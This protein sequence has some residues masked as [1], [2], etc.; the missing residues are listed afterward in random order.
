MQTFE[1]RPLFFLVFARPAVF[2]SLSLT[3]DFECGT[4]SEKTMTVGYLKNYFKEKYGDTFDVVS[5]LFREQRALV[6][7][8]FDVMT[9]FCANNSRVVLSSFFFLKKKKKIKKKY[10]SHKTRE[11]ETCFATFLGVSDAQMFFFLAGLQ[12]ANTDYSLEIAMKR[13]AENPHWSVR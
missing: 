10:K 11:K 1:R 4:V 7:I 2:F 6:D 5:F 12:A 3:G 8:H 13:I 9:R